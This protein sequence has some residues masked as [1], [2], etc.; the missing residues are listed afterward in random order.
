MTI[1]SLGERQHVSVFYSTE[2]VLI[3]TTEKHDPCLKV[4]KKKNYLCSLDR[5]GVCSCSR[6]MSVFDF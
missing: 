1:I 6:Y 3:V 5:N 4:K 2:L